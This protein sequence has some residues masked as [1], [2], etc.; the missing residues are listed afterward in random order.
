[1]DYATGGTIEYSRKVDAHATT[2]YTEG[3]KSGFI[4]RGDTQIVF[5]F[6]QSGPVGVLL[7]TKKSCL[8]IGYIRVYAC[9]KQRNLR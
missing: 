4:V 2:A 6:C 1:M 9:K 5:F 7:F 8:G 3:D